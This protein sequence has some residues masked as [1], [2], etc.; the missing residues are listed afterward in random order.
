[1]QKLAK[2]GCHQLERH[3]M[4]FTVW[5]APNGRCFNIMDPTVEINGKLVGYPKI[6]Y[7]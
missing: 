1:M 6:P 7:A 3:K 2:L 5:Q 4:G